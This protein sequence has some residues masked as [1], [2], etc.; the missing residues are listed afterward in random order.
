MI[1]EQIVTMILLALVLCIFD[2]FCESA[3]RTSNEA[4]LIKSHLTSKHHSR[5]N[6]TPLYFLGLISQRTTGN[7]KI[8]DTKK[9]PRQDESKPVHKGVE[10]TIL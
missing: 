1:P 4:D 5:H 6:P 9:K 2:K 8:P 3:F 7:V 10:N